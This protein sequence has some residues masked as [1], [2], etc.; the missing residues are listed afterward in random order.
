MK[1][2]LPYILIIASVV[3]LY[4]YR[5]IR[6]PQ[7]EFKQEPVVQVAEVGENLGGVTGPAVV[8]FYAS[9]C[10]PCMS[11]ME[12]L[13]ALVPEYERY[14]VRFFLVTDDN[15]E[16]LQMLGMRYPNLN[17]VQQIPSLKDLGVHSIPA[18]YWIN[19][20]QEIVRKNTG[21]ND[22]GVNL[23]NQDVAELLKK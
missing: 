13:N 5:Y 23:L 4:W 15:D 7:I 8:H 2:S 20:K 10:R 9:W 19:E 16:E 18:T 17:R 12:S 11:E 3:V 6:A 22:W 1:K 21:K 14:G